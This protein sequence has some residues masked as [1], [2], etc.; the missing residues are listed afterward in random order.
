MENTQTQ[1]KKNSGI[2]IAVIIVIGI[3]LFLFFSRSQEKLSGVD[4]RLPSEIAHFFVL[5]TV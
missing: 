2:I 1:V 3:G 4:D 5:D